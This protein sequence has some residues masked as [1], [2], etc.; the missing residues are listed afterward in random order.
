[1]IFIPDLETRKKHTKY[2]TNY[3]TNFLEYFTS[4]NE[5]KAYIVIFFHSLLILP[6]S[7]Y[8][9]FGKINALYYAII[10]ELIIIFLLHFYFNGCILIRIERELFND[11]DW[12]GQWT[13]PFII[14]KKMG[15]EL[16]PRFMTNLFICSAILI[17]LFIFLR[18]AFN[19]D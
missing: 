10:V 2:L 6:S 3:I 14:L 11:K 7:A 17:S 13:V 5:I 18:L 4:D 1:M 12:F 8:I 19:F 9:L 16:T 15:M